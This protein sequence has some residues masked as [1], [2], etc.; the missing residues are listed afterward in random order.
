[1]LAW[2]YC[3]VSSL[4]DDDAGHFRRVSLRPLNGKIS[5]QFIYLQI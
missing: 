4:F 2:D 5:S 3:H 1:M